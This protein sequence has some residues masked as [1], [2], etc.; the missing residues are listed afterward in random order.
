VPDDILRAR[1]HVTEAFQ[2]LLFIDRLAG[3]RLRR[4]VVIGDD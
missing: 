2:H 1:M 3:D 4:F